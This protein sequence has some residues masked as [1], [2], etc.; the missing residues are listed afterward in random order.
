MIGEL[1]RF[2]RVMLNGLLNVSKEFMYNCLVELCFN[3]SV[4]KKIFEG[5]ME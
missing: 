5:L 2:G 1:K 4:E 3:V